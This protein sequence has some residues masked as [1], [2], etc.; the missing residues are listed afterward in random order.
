MRSP[1]RGGFELGIEAGGERHAQAS[2]G[3]TKRPKEPPSLPSVPSNPTQA[4]C[5]TVDAST[6]RFAPGG[7]GP[8]RARRN[9][10]AAGVGREAPLSTSF[11]RSRA[12]APPSPRTTHEVSH[13]RENADPP[14]CYVAGRQEV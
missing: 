1:D 11:D 3:K 10:R 12:G 7:P 2:A 9:V 13:P 4:P 14:V 6:D 8:L 5:S